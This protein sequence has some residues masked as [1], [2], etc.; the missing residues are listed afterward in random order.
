MGCL[1]CA[2]TC[3]F[4]AIEEKVL[5]S[6]KKIAH[7]IETVCQGCG[8]CTSTCPPG[9]IQLQQCTDNQLIAEVDALCQ[10]WRQ[11]SFG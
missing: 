2:D 11:R 3:P 8:V 1:K 4:K 9:A 7:V 5:P 6:G 10:A